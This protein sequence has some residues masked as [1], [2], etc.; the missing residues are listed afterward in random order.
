MLEVLRGHGLASA[1]SERARAPSR[2]ALFEISKD[3]RDDPEGDVH[4]VCS[5]LRK[6][7]SG[8]GRVAT[9]RKDFADHGNHPAA[10]EFYCFEPVADRLGSGGEDEVEPAAFHGGDCPCDLLCP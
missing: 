1:L 7:Q 3:C 4:E 5:F 8:T 2:V 6:V 9:I 10:V